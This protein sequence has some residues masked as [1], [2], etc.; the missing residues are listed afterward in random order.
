MPS[1]SHRVQSEFQGFYFSYYDRLPVQREV[2]KCSYLRK[3][4]WSSVYREKLTARA[5]GS[6]CDI[7]LWL[8]A[9]GFTS[10]FHPTHL[11][12][13]HPWAWWCFMVIYETLRNGWRFNQPQIKPQSL[14]VKV[15]GKGSVSGQAEKL[16]SQIPVAPAWAQK[17]LNAAA[18][19]FLVHEQPLCEMKAK[20][21]SATILLR[22]R[23]SFT[24]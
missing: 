20:A 23:I 4:G 1:E 8:W 9:G 21:N 18:E 22:F 12:H 14:A 24:S 17:V 10:V 2:R 13:L 11:Q 19:T 3:E 15:Q 16:L 7:T 6:C 5:P